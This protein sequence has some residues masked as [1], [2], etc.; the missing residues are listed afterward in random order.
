MGDTLEHDGH[1]WARQGDK[2]C[3]CCNVKTFR[4]C[5]RTPT[6]LIWERYPGPAGA[7]TFTSRHSGRVFVLC[8]TCFTRRFVEDRQRVLQWDEAR[9]RHVAAPTS[10]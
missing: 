7:H 8:H 1:T 9:T 6:E 3:S 5:R 2:P 4:M 10:R